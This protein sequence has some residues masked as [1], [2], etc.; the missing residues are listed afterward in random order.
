MHALTLAM[1]TYGIS[2]QSV[3]KTDGEDGQSRSHV[4]KGY[5]DCVWRITPGDGKPMLVKG[6]V[7]RFEVCF[8][9][10]ASRD[11]RST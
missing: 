1:Y 6:Y 8:R 11:G 10:T 5:S 3:D 9:G 4:S 7:G 2:A